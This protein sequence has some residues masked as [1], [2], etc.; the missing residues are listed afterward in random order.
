MQEDVDRLGEW[1][2]NNAMK[3]NPS[4]SKAIHFTRARVKDPLN[5]SIMDMLT[6]EA[7]ICKYLGII[8]CSDLSWVNHVNY[9]VKKGLESTTFHDENTKKGK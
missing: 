8:L 4:K 7:N 1:A 2:C 3:I 9:M 5:Y 6:L